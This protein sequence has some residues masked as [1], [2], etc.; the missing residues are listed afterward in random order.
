MSKWIRHLCVA[1]V[2]L[3]TAAHIAQ[4]APWGSRSDPS[5]YLGKDYSGD[6]L[7]A[8]ESLRSGTRGY[9]GGQLPRTEQTRPEK[10]PTSK[11]PKPPS[12]C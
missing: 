4:A 10:A 11:H 5:V 6:P 2:V 9:M 3:A 1:A 12:C 8:L 7:G